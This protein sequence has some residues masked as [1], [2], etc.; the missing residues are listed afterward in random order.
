[1]KTLP[2]TFTL[3]ALAA[4]AIGSILTFRLFA[5]STPCPT[6]PEDL[7]YI[8]LISKKTSPNDSLKLKDPAAFNKLL[9]LSSGM[10]SDVNITSAQKAGIDLTGVNVTQRVATNNKAD[11]QAVLDS[12]VPPTLSP[13]A[14][15]TPTP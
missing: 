11:F 7:K 15:P 3:V 4:I 8:L 6:P 14:K 1:M 5:Q 12:F 2:G 13:T 9:N 10:Q